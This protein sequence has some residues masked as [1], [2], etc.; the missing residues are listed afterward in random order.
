[1]SNHVIQEGLITGEQGGEGNVKCASM[2]GEML[3]HDLYNC[4]RSFWS[5]SKNPSEPYC[6]R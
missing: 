6:T 2:S 5:L 1:M 4:V 3:K